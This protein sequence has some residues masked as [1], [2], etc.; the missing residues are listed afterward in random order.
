[1][2]QDVLC[3]IDLRNEAD[4]VQWANEVN[5]KRPW[6]YE[7]FDDYAAEISQ[8][9][10]NARILELGSG[11]GYLASHVLKH[12]PN[13]QY[14]AFDFSDAMHTLAKNRL[15]ASELNRIQFVTG[16]FKDR[17]WP[18]LLLQNLRQQQSIELNAKAAPAEPCIGVFDVIIIHQALHELRHKC[19]AAQFHQAVQMLM[20][21][22]SVYFVCDHIYAS[23][24]MQNNELYMSIDE[25]EEGLTQAGFNKIKFIKNLKGLALFRVQ[26]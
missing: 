5:V 6:R 19:H 13:I 11:P 25:H 14:T 2:Q 8:H 4:A 18:D 12:C 10:P 23:D 16:N 24:A 21:P 22:H 20:H 1:M 9:A 26:R 17:H 7:I 3:P 15:S